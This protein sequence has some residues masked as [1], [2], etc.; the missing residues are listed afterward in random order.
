LQDGSAERARLV[1]EIG[2]ELG[3]DPVEVLPVDVGADGGPEAAARSARYAAL[4]AV[5]AALDACVLLGHTLDDQAETVLLG[6]GRGSGP[7]SIAGMPAANGRYLRPFLGVRRSVTE[8]ACAALGLQPWED[9]HNSD[10]SFQRVRLRTEVL[11]L[12]EDVLQGGV[13]EALARTADLVRADL[14]F[15]DQQIASIATQPSTS[16]DQQTDS[17]GIRSDWSVDHDGGALRAEALAELPGA[18][19]TRAL[20]AWAAAV[21]AASLTSVHIASLDAL[22]TGW[23]GQGA[24]DLPGGVRV[25]RASGRIEVIPPPPDQQEP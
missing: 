25:R 21:G 14:E 11:P 15:V 4:D 18:L 19:R 7:R 23:H 22:V 13:A 3:L 12:L 8:D 2:Y 9:P 16:G 24:V 10:P 17:T 20:R 1:A 5:A 6:L